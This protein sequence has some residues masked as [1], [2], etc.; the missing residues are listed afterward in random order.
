MSMTIDQSN[1]DVSD[2]FRLGTVRLFAVDT[3]PKSVTKAG[4][5]VKFSYDQT[6]KVSQDIL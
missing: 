1:F 3:K 6:T 4:E 5:N 2:T